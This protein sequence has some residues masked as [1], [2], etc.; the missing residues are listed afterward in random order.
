MSY[1]HFFLLAWLSLQSLLT[2]SCNSHFSRQPLKSTKLFRS[3]RFNDLMSS[4]S[5]SSSVLT[6]SSLMWGLTGCVSC[7]WNNIYIYIV[8]IFLGMWSLRYFF[9]FNFPTFVFNTASQ[10]S[11]DCLQNSVTTFWKQSGDM[12]ENM[13]E[14]MQQCRKTFHVRI[15]LTV[16]VNPNKAR[17]K[18]PTMNKHNQSQ[19][20]LRT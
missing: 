20:V 1:L 6:S 12:W 11:P 17:W 4:K 5:I 16:K 10:M 3:S 13:L 7:I 8:Y 9:S 15:L 2:L 19:N 14:K 18:N